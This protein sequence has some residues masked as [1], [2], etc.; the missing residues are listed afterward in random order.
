MRI[1]I[2]MLGF[3]PGHIG[4]T[5]TYL[6]QLASHAVEAAGSDTV[7]LVLTR[8]NAGQFPQ[9]GEQRVV[10]DRSDARLVSARMLEAFTPYRAWFA[11][12]ALAEANPDIVLFPQQS[13]FPK[14]VSCPCVLTV[15]D[16][17]H[18]YLPQYVS[19]AERAFRRGIYPYSL[20]RADHIIANS[21]FTRKTLIE[22]CG[23]PGQD[24]TVTLQGLTKIE[25]ALIR[26]SDKV[27][28]PYLYYPAAT[29]PHKGHDVLLKTFAALRSREGF[30]YKLVLTGLKTP[31]WNALLKLIGRLG[32][33]A[34]VV[35]MGFIPRQEVLELFQGAS[36]VLF[37]TMFEGFGRPVW[38]AAQFRK[39]VIVSRLEVFEEI[40]VPGRFQID[41]SDPDQFLSALAAQGPTELKFQPWTAH[42][43][44]DVTFDVLR[45]TA[46]AN[47]A[48]R[49]AC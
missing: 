1:A 46:H 45:A 9:R 23:L 44:V 42:Q 18:L 41:F 17:L 5:E 8:D 26:P 10:V 19:L 25:T 48:G 11:E 16:L 27:Q 21:A 7:I 24:I 34:E 31:H 33:S 39:K 13:I 22:R 35:H 47:P 37:P 49:P 32:I 2:S 28:G 15:H 40:G 30:N 6:R 14:R 43:M 20:Q 3:R 29:F 38:E 36:A 12:R 4:G